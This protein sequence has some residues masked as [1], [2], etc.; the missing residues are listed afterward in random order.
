MC[1][2][3][4]DVLDKEGSLVKTSYKCMKKTVTDLFDGFQMDDMYIKY[5]CIADESSKKETS[6][7]LNQAS[8]NSLNKVYLTFASLFVLLS[9]LG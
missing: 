7:I 5:Q 8:T 1:C 4:V 9:A 2:T 6:I 3:K